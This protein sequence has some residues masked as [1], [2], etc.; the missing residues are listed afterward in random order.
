MDAILYSRK[1]IS[2]DITILG[3][4]NQKINKNLINYCRIWLRGGN[5]IHEFFNQI[6][7]LHL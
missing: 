3:D 6:P 4:E 2:I 5:G 1:M 7:S